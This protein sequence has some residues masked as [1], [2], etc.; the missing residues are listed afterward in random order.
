[1]SAAGE[2]RALHWVGEPLLLPNAWDHAS[3]AAFASLGFPAVGTTSLGVAAAAGL[4]DGAGAAADETVELAIALCG[5]PFYVSAD[6]EGGFSDDPGAVAA[7]CVRLFEA[8]VVGVN[9]EDGRADGGLRAVADHAAIVGAVTE[10]VPDLF[11]NARTDVAWLGVGGVDDAIARV[12]A[13]AD[14]GADGVFVPGVTDR[15]ELSSIASAVDVPLNALL[16]ARWAVGCR[17]GLARCAPGELR[18][19][20]VQGWPAGGGGRAAQGGGRRRPLGAAGDLVRRRAGTRAGVGAAGRAHFGAVPRNRGGA[21]AGAG[22]VVRGV[23][24]GWPGLRGWCRG[25]ASRAAAAHSP[26]DGV[27]TQ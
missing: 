3:A 9:I 26:P 11:V 21:L 6:I 1:M 16:V 5:G 25:G 2:F 27:R 24:S 23:N 18:F 12:Q 17:T 4:R 8:G 22:F 20:V 7:L 14:A 15:G 10:A 19:V 13:Y